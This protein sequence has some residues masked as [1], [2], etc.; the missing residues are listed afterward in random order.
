MTQKD[1][2][3]LIKDLKP[4]NEVAKSYDFLFNSPNSKNKQKTFLIR[5][6][7]ENKVSNEKI[8]K[9]YDNYFNN[10]NTYF[11][12]NSPIR[13]GKKHEIT[14]ISLEIKSTKKPM[15][16]RNMLNVSN[17]SRKKSVL[18][19]IS[20]TNNSNGFENKFE[21][22]DN[23]KLDNIFNSYKK[24]INSNKKS[25]NSKYINKLPLS[26]SISLD[27]QQKN[28]INHRN[29]NKKNINI[30][31][32]LSKKLHEK[33]DDLLMNKVNNFLYKKEL[34][35]NKRNNNSLFKIEDRY[36]WL[37][38]LR[39]PDKFRGIRKTLVNIN[40]EKNPFWGFVFEKSAN[41]KQTVIHPG[42]NLN[43]RNIQNFVK[44]TQSFSGFDF[45]KI[46]N[47]DEINIKG[48]NLFNFEYDREM[49]SKKRKI[50]HKVFVING[51]IV[52]NTDINN[53]FGKE[54]FYKN[55]E[56]NKRI[57]SPFITTKNLKQLIL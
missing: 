24:L 41:M 55:Y 26:I 40:T 15:N 9:E 19:K 31:N 33:K 57:F 48:E 35:N 43:N 14:D 4:N 8:A 49:S 11:S 44:K 13:I 28:L 42:I 53:T 27:N 25:S 17:I 37:T 18:T 10:P 51:K 6:F 16:K 54:T 50:L 46:K 21:I 47:L 30:L 12:S 38:S 29:N 34:I 23:K 20:K 7:N 3:K 22:I 5:K 52:L 56:N 2:Y 1:I 36:K 45:N 32:Y 39:N